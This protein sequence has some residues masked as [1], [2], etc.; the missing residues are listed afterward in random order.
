MDV[1]N[2][3]RSVVDRARHKGIL[4]YLRQQR[5]AIATSITVR[6]HWNYVRATPYFSNNLSNDLLR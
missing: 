4:S 6:K 3:D 1:N 5:N 2:Q